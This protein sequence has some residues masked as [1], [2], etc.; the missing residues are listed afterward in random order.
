[1]LALWLIVRTGL[2]LEGTCPLI[3]PNY[4]FWLGLAL[5]MLLAVSSS[6]NNLDEVTNKFQ[7]VIVISD[8]VSAVWCKMSR[9]PLAQV[10]D[11]AI[12]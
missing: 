12:M 9:K 8:G 4:L 2:D 11:I 10:Q 7:V 1:M 5:T 6:I 3:R